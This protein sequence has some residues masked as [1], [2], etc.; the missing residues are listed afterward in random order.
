[1]RILVTRPAA[2][3]EEWV[4]QLQRSGLDAVALPLMAIAA[5]H[6]LA[7]VRQAWIALPSRQLVFFVSPNA[8]EWFFSQQVEPTTWPASLQA[9]SPGPGTSAVLRRCGVPSHLVVEPAAD[10]PQ[11]DSEALW[12][13]LQNLTWAHASV[14]VVRGDG[15][16]DWLAE[17]LR[18]AGAEVSFVSA[19]RRVAPHFDALELDLAQ[20]AIALPQRH[21]WFF[22][23]SEAVVNLMDAPQLQASGADWSG[24]KALATHPRIADSAKAAGFG[25]VLTS[26]PTLQAVVEQVRACIQSGDG[27]HCRE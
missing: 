27:E 17:Q 12:S 3:A 8:A 6:D 15:G 25:T 7:A 16:R 18:E 23:S 19:Y 2:Q 13:V 11:F 21:I 24:G 10:A 14:L 5:P 4:V 22:S 9:A 1:M 26:R 20:A